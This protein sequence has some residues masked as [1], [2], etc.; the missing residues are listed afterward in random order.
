[1]L[2]RSC[3]GRL[4]RTSADAATRG[5][6]TS[7]SEGS[8]RFQPRR[9]GRERPPGEVRIARHSLDGNRGSEVD[10]GGGRGSGRPKK[11][12]FS[13]GQVRYSG[14]RGSRFSIRVRG[15]MLAR[16]RRFRELPDASNRTVLGS[17]GFHRRPTSGD[18]RRVINDPTRSPPHVFSSSFSS[19][20]SPTR[21]SHVA[22]HPPHRPEIGRA[23]V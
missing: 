14:G 8:G 5:S 18:H 23:H 20:R 6:P 16:H 17:G 15:V 21:S 3:C 4:R 22:T 12:G 10:C 7:S 13:D 2:F 19:S 11:V 9:G 1:M